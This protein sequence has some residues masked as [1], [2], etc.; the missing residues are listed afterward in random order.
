MN[1]ET[2]I[3]SSLEKVFPTQAPS[4]AATPFSCLKGEAFAFQ[5][6]VFPSPHRGYYNS[7]DLRIRAAYT[8]SGSSPADSS[9]LPVQVKQVGYVP[10]QLPCYADDGRY[11]TSSPGLFPDP[12]YPETA[13]GFRVLTGRWNSFF[14]EVFPPEDI[15]AGIYDITLT[16]ESDDPLA[17]SSGLPLTLHVPLTILNAVLPPS[18]LKYTCWFH[19]D[20]LADYYQVPVFSEQHWTIMERQLQLAVD[21]GQ[22]MLLTPLFTPPL[23]TGVGLERTTIQLVDVTQTG[24]T[25]QFDFTKLTRWIEMAQRCG[26]RYF[27]MSH[28][29]TQWGAAACPKILATVNGELRQIFG[30]NQ[31][32][33]C[34]EYKAFLSAFLPALTA[35][36]SAMGLQDVT[37]FHLS[38]EPHAD[39]LEQYLKIKEFITP[40][41]QSYPIMDAM[42]DY[43]YYEQGVCAHP[44]VATTA[45]DPFLN[46]KRPE[47]F[48]VYYCCSQG[49][50]H[51]SNRFMAMP[52]YRTRILGLQCYKEN[53]A[54]FLQW[55]LNFY[56]SRYSMR[57][58]NPFYET[59][60]DGA[61]PSGDAFMIYPGA[62]GMP[63]ESQRLVIFHEALQDL[64]A[65]A[66]LERLTSRE[67]VLALMSCDDMGN[68]VEPISFTTYP[69]GEAYLLGLRHRVNQ[70]IASALH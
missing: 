51:L 59:D 53:V 64:A 63:L 31:L 50:Q 60:G 66:L 25:Y 6:A 56:N 57:H 12:L 27:E 47:E 3:L 32:A 30:W 18:T 11:L 54:G 24:D 7:F 16:L 5:L 70:E 15:A 46:G 62:D 19:G 45:L 28:L 34:A 41:L 33:L 49:G 4:P 22:N 69:T 23:D 14:I 68:P 52:G 43:S 10:S 42:S 26:I 35:Y 29:F 36:L 39:H 8:V 21:R 44:V 67:H 48:W 20:C 1:I 40:L 61:F 38:D 55:A 2:R 58:L 37:Y 65:L 9:S 13:A 17:P